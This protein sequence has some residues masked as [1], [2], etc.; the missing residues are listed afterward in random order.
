MKQWR[1]LRCRDFCSACLAFL[2]LLLLSIHVRNLVRLVESGSRI[3]MFVVCVTNGEAR[4]DST[5]PDSGRVFE[6]CVCA[7]GKVKKQSKN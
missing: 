2:G 7:R 4:N 6:T 3:S 1:C 5:Q